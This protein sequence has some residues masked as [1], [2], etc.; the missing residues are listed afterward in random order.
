MEQEANDYVESL[1]QLDR[2]DFERLLAYLEEER[3]STISSPIISECITESDNEYD[4]YLS[5]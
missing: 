1:E 5:E 3:E 4:G 2:Q